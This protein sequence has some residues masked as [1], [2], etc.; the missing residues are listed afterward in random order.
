MARV[1]LTGASGLLG[2]RLAPLLARDHTVVAAV[3]RAPAP[4]GFATVPFDLANPDTVAVAFEAARP[5]AVIHAA[6]L[7]DADACEREPERAVAL[8]VTGTALLAVTCARR[9][10]RLVVLSTD[11]VFDGSKGGLREDDLA[12][13]LLHY[14][15]TKLEAEKEALR[16][17]SGSV[18]VRVALVCGRGHGPRATASEAVAWA[19]ARGQRPRLFTDQH[20]TPVDPES[21]AVALAALVRGRGEGRYHLGG[22]ERVSRYELGARVA[23]ALRLDAAVL[24]ATTQASHPGLPRP[25]DVSL[26]STRARRELGFA[27]RP[28]DEMIRSGRPAPL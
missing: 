20:R 5:D 10:A 12:Q 2:G 6:A 23:S 14:G 25:A 17:C 8:N 26:D 9:G 16:R 18:V 3:H 22:A 19:V 13:P 28:L 24:E 11:L 27:P 21:V 4:D 1:L 7:A 15:R